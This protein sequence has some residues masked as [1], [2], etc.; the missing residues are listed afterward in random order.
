MAE[1]TVIIPHHAVFLIGMYFIEVLVTPATNFFQKQFLFYVVYSIK[2]LSGMKFYYLAF[3]Y[4]KDFIL[5]FLAFNILKIFFS[6][7]ILFHFY[8][9]RVF[10][11]K[12]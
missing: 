9:L 6:L 2:N 12:H 5:Y 10:C 1:P 8:T 4:H 3:I 7:S 11:I